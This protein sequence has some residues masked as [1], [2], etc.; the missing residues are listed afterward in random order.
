MKTNVRYI[1]R[2]AAIII[3]LVS[4]LILCS[5]IFNI[6]GIDTRLPGNLRIK[7]NTALCFLFAGTSLLLLDNSAGKKYQQVIASV[8][9]YLI[10]LIAGLTLMEYIF[11]WDAGIDQLFLNVPSSSPPGSFPGRMSQA[12]AITFLF[13]SVVFLLLHQ[14]RYHLFIQVFLMAA[15]I[16]IT[17]SLIV[18]VTAN[19]NNQSFKYIISVLSSSFIFLLLFAG[20]FFSYPLRYLKF[21]FQKVMA[22]FF[23]LTILVLVIIFLASNSNSIRAKNTTQLLNH[24]NEVLLQN[25]RI[26]NLARDLEAG[27]LRFVITGNEDFLNSFSNALP[28]IS[29]NVQ[30]LRAVTKG[31]TLQQLRIDTIEQL[32]DSNINATKQLIEIRRTKG[33]E[34]ASRLF[35]A[36]NTKNLV[37]QLGPL[38]SAIENYEY[39]K[40]KKSEAANEQNSAN[41]SKVIFLFQILS[42]LLLLSAFFIIYKNTRARN[43]AEAEIKDLNASLEDRVKEKT[44]EVIEKEKQYRFLLQ[45]MREG[46]QVIGYDWKYR[47]VNNSVVKQSK[48]ST[49]ELLG[50]TMMEKYPGIEHTGLFKT[51]QRC[52]TERTSEILENEF[53]FPDGSQ[54]WFELS[55]QP[56]PEGLFILSMDITE[57]KKAEA[58]LIQSLKEVSDYKYAI[59]ESSIVA[60]TDQKGIITHVNDNFCN[61]SKYS[62]EEL[63]GQDHRIINSGYHSK[64]FIRDLWVTI[65]NGKI[66]RGE[67]KNKAKDGSYYWVATT[68][69]PFLN[70]QGKPFQYVAIRSD[71]TDRKNSEMALAESE[72]R[73]RNLVDNSLVGIFESTLDGNIIYANR[74]DLKIFGYDSLE[75]LQAREADSVYKYPQQRKEFIESL[76]KN[77]KVENF[78]ADMLTKTGDTVTLLLNAQV[79][80]N[81][82]S[83]MLMD[84]TEIKKAEEEIIRMNKILESRAAELQASNTELERFAYV[85][86]HDLQEPL[87]MVSSFLNLLE[88]KLNGLLDET[89]RQYIHFA[90]DG[91]ERMKTLIQDLL[92]YS[93]V[94]SN[95][96]GFAPT[97]INE[98]MQYVIRLLADDI[99]KN[100]AVITIHPMPVIVANKTLISQLFVNMVHNAL[101]Y[102]GEK[103]PEIEIGCKEEPRQW[104]FYVK[105][106]GIGIDPKF[107]DKIFII[108]QRLHNKNEYSGTG[109][110]LAICKKIADI[111]KGKIEVESKMGEGTTFYFTIPKNNNDDQGS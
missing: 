7:V 43:K 32:I 51:L 82:I 4:C 92:Q 61:I 83:G 65:A 93:R 77:G 80:D 63:I 21:S 85:A 53:T 40:F 15:I 52:M 56:V 45:N 47:F 13:L 106:N 35:N 96:E 60:F 46:I 9:V 62:R 100:Q 26:L 84:I 55:I 1:S 12:S 41:A 57:R 91:A 67:I 68:I 19:F 95:K 31:D 42:G 70:E 30:Q 5:W 2:I 20:T 36:G 104:T 76:E 73:Y 108:F 110:G 22:G 54:E 89:T 37:A 102:R 97:D 8:L 94:G 3:I 18:I 28:L 87:R 16:I 44:A 86:S 59:N 39:Q 103:I 58:A 11:K 98:V 109:I 24:A 64:E 33:F 105:D 38:V 99:K 101:K 69:I 66:W 27:S 6:P 71:I 50:H 75:E 48:Y 17:L 88:K 79:Y 10:L 34:A 81:K 90:V 107:F 74:A 29:S 49:E 111:H 23:V 25:R 72:K 14:R 78:T